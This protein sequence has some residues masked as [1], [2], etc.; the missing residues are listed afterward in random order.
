MA[1]A[2]IR[3]TINMAKAAMREAFGGRYESPLPQ[4]SDP[5]PKKQRGTKCHKNY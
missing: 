5:S 3:K 4:T 2:A 1:E